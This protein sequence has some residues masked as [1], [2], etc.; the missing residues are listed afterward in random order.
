MTETWEIDKLLHLKENR[1][2]C[3]ISTYL[4][5][6]K[7]AR[8]RD[9][10]NLFNAIEY[11]WR[12]FHNVPYDF[13]KDTKRFTKKVSDGYWCVKDNEY[14]TYLTNPAM[15]VKAMNQLNDM[16]RQSM[17]EEIQLRFDFVEYILNQ[18]VDKIDEVKSDEHQLSISFLEYKL[19]VT[20][21]LQKVYDNPQNHGLYTAQQIKEIADEIGVELE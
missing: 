1:R 5:F 10:H 12:Y 17:T 9:L 3:F 19:K 16:T 7:S 14:D 6:I 4:E 21:I 20:E 2:S 11:D 8:K 18:L 15:I 13:N